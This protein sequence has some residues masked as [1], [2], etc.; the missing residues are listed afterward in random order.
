MTT[1]GLVSTVERVAAIMAA[2][3]MRVPGPG[4]PL[5]APLL[6]VEE[7]L[8]AGFLQEV[9]DKQQQFLLEARQ[10]QLASLKAPKELS[11]IPAN[12][13]LKK[14]MLGRG[15]VVGVSGRDLQ[16]GGALRR[17]PNVILAIVTSSQV[18][19]SNANARERRAAITRNWRSYAA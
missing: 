15:D 16:E 12:D 5:N 8:Q 2:D 10:K 17:V 3:G 6:R 19:G 7:I 9:A 13:P 11:W 14:A 1:T 18:K 4:E